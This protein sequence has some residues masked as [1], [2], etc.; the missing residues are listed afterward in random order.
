MS[1][2]AAEAR[3]HREAAFDP[4][5][6]DALHPQEILSLYAVLAYVAYNLDIRQE[7]VQAILEAEYSVDNVAR[8][9]RN[10]F[11]SAIG[12]LIDLR[13]DSLRSRR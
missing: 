13:M 3:Q 8:I 12:F 9:G 11:Q 2:L 7:L 6:E 5:P 1:A 4:P 10:D